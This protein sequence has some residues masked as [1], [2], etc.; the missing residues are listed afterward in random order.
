MFYWEKA[1]GLSGKQM[2]ASL[3][4]LQMRKLQISTPCSSFSLFRIFLFLCNQQQQHQRLATHC[5]LQRSRQAGCFSSKEEYAAGT[6]CQLVRAPEFTQFTPWGNG[7][8][9]AGVRIELTRAKT[10]QFTQ[11]FLLLGPGNAPKALIV[12]SLS[13]K[14]YRLPRT[15]TF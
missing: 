7:S 4:K 2:T 10:F 5:G 14:V 15:S 11:D 3:I 13:L 12:M 6:P 8:A 9:V 1:R